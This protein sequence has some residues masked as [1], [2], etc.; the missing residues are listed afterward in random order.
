[1]LKW[2]TVPGVY[3]QMVTYLSTNRAQHRVTLLMPAMPSP[4]TQC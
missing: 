2:V 1:V 3:L 4:I